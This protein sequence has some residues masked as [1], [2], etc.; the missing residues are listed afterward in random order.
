MP[1][2]RGPH[3]PSLS[4]LSDS[5]LTFPDS[6][7]GPHQYVGFVVAVVVVLT[8]VVAVPVA[9]AESQA[10]A[11]LRATRAI[12]ASKGV[13]ASKEGPLQTHVAVGAANSWGGP[14]VLL[15]HFRRV[16]CCNYLVLH[17]QR[18]ASFEVGLELAD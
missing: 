5:P 10:A 2:P 3:P 13:L 6:A 18:I 17:H 16:L 14:C 9:G 1:P 7:L 4:S 11:P 8:V 15:P 12:R